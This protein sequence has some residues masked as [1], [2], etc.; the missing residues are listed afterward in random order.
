MTSTVSLPRT[1][2][3]QSLQYVAGAFAERGVLPREGG[4]AILIDLSDVYCRPDVCSFAAGNESFY[5][6]SNHLSARGAL[7]AVPAIA[8]QFDQRPSARIP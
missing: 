3:W 4:R 7:L 1:T 8:A 5:F 2:H 6:D